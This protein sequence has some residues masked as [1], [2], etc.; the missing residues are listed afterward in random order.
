MSNIEQISDTEIQFDGHL[1]TAFESSKRILLS[2]GGKLKSADIQQ[3][4]IDVR[5][6]YGINPFGLRIKLNFEKIN[7]STFRVVVLGDFVDSID[8]FGAAKKKAISITQKLLNGMNTEL[9]TSIAPAP[10]YTQKNTSVKN[11]SGQIGSLG[12]SNFLPWLTVIILALTIS[13]IPT[14]LGIFLVPLFGLT[15]ALLTLPLSRWLAKRAHNIFVIDPQNPDHRNFQELYLT[16]SELAEKA[17]IPTPEVGVY[18]SKDMNAFATGMN[19]KK[20]IV[21]FSSALL[22]KLTPLEVQAVA[23]HEV[24]HIVSK[25]MMAM[26]FFQGLTNSL[27]L[28]C[29]LPLQLARL[30]VSSSQDKS[31]PLIDW[32]IWL[33]K[34]ALTVMLT[35]FGSLALIAFSRRREYRADA[36]A[37]L[38][39]GKEGMISAL[40]KISVDAEEAPLQQKSYSAMKISTKQQFAEWFS[41]HPLIESRI[42]ALELE[43]HTRPSKDKTPKVE[44]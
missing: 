24:G 11:I 10:L 13:G 33:L 19:P 35:F 44:A 37:A 30:L 6:R 16:V 21:A 27:I 31:A 12:N 7:E 17:G 39:V 3:G 8:T 20:S 28:L 42:Q 38:L 34:A 32:L 1:A 2:E 26:A 23:A 36:I 4:K 22:E 5:F 41:T 9:L 29:T 15:G 25:D 18:E 43:T 40:R 14:G